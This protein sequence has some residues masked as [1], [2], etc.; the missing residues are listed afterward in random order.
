MPPR[1]TTRQLSAFI[2]AA[3]VNNFT[4]AASR[5][6]LTPS[7]VSNLIGELE[8]A[9]G[10]SIFERTTRKIALTAEGRQFL[11]VAIAVQRRFTMA[12]AAAADIAN[13]TADVV[14]VA[15]PLAVAATLLP[16]IIS[17]YRDVEPR[18]QVRVIDTGV[19][20]MADRLMS[21]EADL[22][23]GPDRCFGAD[24]NSTALFPSPWVLWC[25]PD[26]P[27]ADTS[28]LTWSDLEG[29]DFF[30]AGRDH[31]DSVGPLGARGSHQIGNAPLQV[32][33]CITTA[34]GMAAANLGVTFSPQYVSRL[35]IPMGL[36]MRRILE[37]EIMRHVTLYEPLE[38][39]PP[40]KV[41]L[42]R[43]FIRS[44][45]TG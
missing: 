38:V 11:P 34:L 32:F 22:A 18:T 33:D 2:A 25:S 35:A 42:L 7:A 45:A 1:F 5:L 44:M 43:D 4:L 14:R 29:V 3:E 41:R 37:P 12:G 13:R 15:A 23:V 19:E 26:H 21:G 27:L 6:N 28:E 17:A 31:E 8:A 10:F 20:W 16:P 36:T 24:I 39:D 9:V 30:T 40:A